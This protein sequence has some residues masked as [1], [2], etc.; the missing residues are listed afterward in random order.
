MNGRLIIVATI[1]GLAGFAGGVPFGT[2]P[3][4]GAERPSRAPVPMPPREHPPGE[5][6]RQIK[7]QGELLAELAGK[8]D[9]LA[10]SAA[11]QE[12]RGSLSR[13]RAAPAAVDPLP[14]PEAMH[15]AEELVGAALGTGVW[16]EHDRDELRG[17]LPHLEAARR[18]ALMRKLIVA[19]NNGAMHAQ[20]TG[21]PF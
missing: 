15:R 1:A 7:E 21:P 20:V 12:S 18:E 11:G 19:L 3:R 5:L 17:L 10:G 2:S 4:N 6:V 14:D 8:I 16:S 13:D 9:R